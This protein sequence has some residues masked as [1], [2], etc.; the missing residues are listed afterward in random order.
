MQILRRFRLPRTR[1]KFAL[2]MAGL[3][4]RRH[5]PLSTLHAFPWVLRRRAARLLLRL[6]A[7]PFRRQRRVTRAARVGVLVAEAAVGAGLPL[8]AEAQRDDP[9]RPPL[10]LLLLPPRLRTRPPAGRTSRIGNDRRNGSHWGAVLFARQQ[11]VIRPLQ[12][13]IMPAEPTTAS[14]SP[15]TSA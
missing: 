2:K 8:Q 3:L 9:R 14:R 12:E 13:K 10:L 5:Q 15:E 11:I 4:L 6:H 1:R 7:T